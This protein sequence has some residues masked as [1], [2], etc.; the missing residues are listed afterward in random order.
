MIR[1]PSWQKE[2]E[3]AVYPRPM[4]V[5]KG[6]LEVRYE[7]GMYIHDIVS[8]NGTLLEGMKGER[9]GG[10]KGRVGRMFGGRGVDGGGGR[11]T[12]QR[13]VTAS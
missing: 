9:K 1:G 12:M 7:N 4:D 11:R 6:P 10:L 13:S 8:P 3:S 2:I 5:N